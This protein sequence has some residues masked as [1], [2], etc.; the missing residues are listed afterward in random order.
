MP[1][2]Y[3]LSLPTVTR[4]QSVTMSAIN[5]VDYEA[6][7]FTFQGQAQANA[8]Q[9]WKADVV[10]PPMRR[11]QAAEW[12]TNLVSLRGSFGTFLMG[13]PLACLARGSVG[14]SP[15]V[16][17][18]GQTGSDLNITGATASQTGWIK[19]GDYIQLG[20]AGTANLHQVLID[21]DSD[22]SGNVTL[23]LWPH[24][25]GNQIPASGSVVVVSNPVGNWRL[26]SSTTTFNI[27]SLAIY[28]ITFG[29]IEAIQ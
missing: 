5:A 11:T 24:I 3:P 27:D 7:P 26:S 2:T 21:A 1:I 18:G 12:V 16:L 17:G 29:A 13:N 6:S 20:S 22:A 19:A 28:G 23:V 9:M 8:G 4:I 10:L 14:G 15:V 25:R